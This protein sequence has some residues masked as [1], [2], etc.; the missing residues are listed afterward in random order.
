MR[1]QLLKGSAEQLK[2]KLE[3]HF[4]ISREGDISG[5]CSE[6]EGHVGPE[7]SGV[8]DIGLGWNLDFDTLGLCDLSDFTSL[9]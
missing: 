4:P 2:R 5:S 1:R 3:M 6:S 7:N 9:S 8:K